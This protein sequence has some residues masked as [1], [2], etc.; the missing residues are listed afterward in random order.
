RASEFAYDERHDVLSRPGSAGRFTTIA[1]NRCEAERKPVVKRVFH[2]ECEEPARRCAR[3]ERW[4]DGK[5][6]RQGRAGASAR[7][8][9][10]RERPRRQGRVQIT[11][12]LK[13]PTVASS[14]ERA[15]RKS[16]EG[17]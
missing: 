16:E 6:R 5:G 1:N 12:R 9:G 3:G 17:K 13:S 14:T 4:V 7:E 11:G 15:E 2:G 10:W 8:G